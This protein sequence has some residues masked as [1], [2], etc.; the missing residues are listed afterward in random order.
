M[1]KLMIMTAVVALIGIGLPQ[2]VSANLIKDTQSMVQEN[3]QE[4]PYTEIKLA[5]LPAVISKAIDEKY[6][7]FKVEKAYYGKDG[8]YKVTVSKAEERVNLFYNEKGEFLKVD[9]RIVSI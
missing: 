9:K 4:N 8:S 2:I 7:G 5:D 1:K 3:P 6:P